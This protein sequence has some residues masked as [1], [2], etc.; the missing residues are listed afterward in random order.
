MSAA[1]RDRREDDPVGITDALD[2]VVRSWRGGDGRATA[3]VFASWEA[4]VGEHIARHVRPVQLD[5]GRLVVEVD[6]PA[7]ST[8]VRFLE[9]EVLGR[10]ATVVGP[11]RVVT[12]EVRV[13]RR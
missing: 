11:G 6:D 5:D 12:L 8:Q 10:L 13:R 9:A 1:G 2:A 7:W 3:S 4:A